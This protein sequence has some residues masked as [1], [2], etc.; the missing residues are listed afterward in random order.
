MRK[1]NY[2]ELR[3]L[4]NVTTKHV[5]ALRA[6][7]RLVESWDDL[8]IHI[9]GNKLDSITFRDWEDTLSGHELPRLEQL[10]NFLMKKCQTLE[11]IITKENASSLLNKSNQSNTRK[12]SINCTAAI[13]SKCSYCS[14][15]SPIYFRQSFTKLPIEQR[16]GE[17]KKRSLCI[18]CMRSKSHVAKQ[19]TSSSCKTCGSR[20]NTLLHLTKTKGDKDPTTKELQSTKDSAEIPKSPAV[21]THSMS[22]SNENYALLSTALVNVFDVDGN[23][24]SCRVLLDNGAQVNLI[25]KNFLTKLRVNLEPSGTTYQFLASI[26]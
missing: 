11:S 1:E 21:V 19:C 26:K 22:G 9:L 5:N 4:L 2:S 20:H 7:K 10:T 12:S 15:E 24:L 14:G 6:L 8:I 16:I 13:K 25:T 18:N 3:L 17:V 23:K